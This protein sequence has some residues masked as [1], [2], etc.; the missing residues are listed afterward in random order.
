MPVFARDCV[1]PDGMITPKHAVSLL[2]RGAH[3]TGVLCTGKIGVIV[4]TPGGAA[5]TLVTA[6]HSVSGA[7]H[8]EKNCFMIFIQKGSQINIGNNKSIFFKKNNTNLYK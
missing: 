4:S 5:K 6:V 7:S 2:A 1:A 3:A 8:F